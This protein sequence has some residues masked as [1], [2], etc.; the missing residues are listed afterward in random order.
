MMSSQKD[1]FIGL[2]SPVFKPLLTLFMQHHFLFMLTLIHRGLPYTTKFLQFF[3]S[4]KSI[5]LLQCVQCKVTPDFL[6]HWGWLLQILSVCVQAGVCPLE[7]FV[8]ILECPSIPR[9][10]QSISAFTIHS[11]D[12]SRVEPTWTVRC[13]VKVKQWNHQDK[14]KEPREGLMEVK[15]DKLKHKV[16]MKGRNALVWKVSVVRN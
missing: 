2:W 11:I 1:L 14:G 5:I 15:Q 6:T 7:G 16:Q 13:D 3:I 8:S 10:Q 12:L 4:N 9:L